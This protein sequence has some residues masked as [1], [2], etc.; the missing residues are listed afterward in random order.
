[1]HDLLPELRRPYRFVI[2]G[3]ILGIPLVAVGN[4]ASLPVIKLGGVLIVSLTLIALAVVFVL[5]ALRIGDARARVLLVIAGASVLAGMSLAVI[6]GIGELTGRAW[7]GIPQ[8]ARWHAPINA[9]GFTLPGLLAHVVWRRRAALAG[10][11]AV[12]ERSQ[13][14]QAPRR[15]RT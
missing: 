4:I 13:M 15:P 14:V 8:M 10:A 1:V 12:E 5:L 9:L 2:A 6:Y 3:A 11:P 7:I